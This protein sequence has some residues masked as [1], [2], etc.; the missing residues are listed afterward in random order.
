MHIFVAN[1]VVTSFRGHHLK[2]IFIFLLKL[3]NAVEKTDAL[4]YNV[5]SSYKL[6]TNTHREH[7][8]TAKRAQTGS[9]WGESKTFSPFEK[10]RQ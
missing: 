5:D 7:M 1:E 4:M 8:Y 6:R 9:T 10:V 3:R 2:I